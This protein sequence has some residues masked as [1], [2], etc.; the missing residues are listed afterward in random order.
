[1]LIT[2]LLSSYNG[3]KYIAEQLDSVLAQKLPED[4]SLKIIVRDDGSS[5]STLS[6]LDEYVKNHGEIISYYTGENLKPAR[7][8]LHLLKNCPASDCYAFCDQDDVWLEDKLSRALAALQAEANQDIPLLYCSN[9][10]ATD[11][12]LNPIGLIN[13]GKM[14]TDLAHVLIYVVSNGCTQVFN[15]AAREELIQ[16]DMDSNLEIMHDRLAELTTAILGK[17]I[18]DETPTMLY[19]Q[20]GNNV[21]GEQSIGRFKSFFKRVKR[22]MGSSDSIR[23]ERCKMFLRL[24]GDRPDEEKKRLLYV[25]GNY[26]TDKKARKTLMKDKAFKKSKKADFWFRWAVRLKKI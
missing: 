16:Y 7:S 14:Y 22:F 2:V 6:V 26:K 24:Y 10:T 25:V 23:S 3:E 4:W 20:H 12:D 11:K 19:R 21:V 13:G 1:M 5:D 15:N 18:Y 9:A 8:F 17:M